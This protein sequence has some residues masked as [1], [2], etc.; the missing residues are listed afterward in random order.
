LGSQLVWYHMAGQYGPLLL[1]SVPAPA[2]RSRRLV[3]QAESIVLA[4][5]QAPVEIAA[6]CQTLAVSERT[7]RKAF[8]KV[9]RLPPCRRLRWLRLSHARWALMSAGG[10]S[11]TEI[12]TGFGFV[13]LGRFSVEY[14]KVFGERPSETLRQ[15]MLKQTPKVYAIGP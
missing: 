1:D 6:L 11:V 14:R 3:D 8:Q 10:S 15:A 4:N 5:V 9:H 12:A 2:D 13:E 7:L